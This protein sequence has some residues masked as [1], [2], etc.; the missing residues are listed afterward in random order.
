MEKMERN[1]RERVEK[2]NMRAQAQ[3]I[4][5]TADVYDRI[6][7]GK[8]DKDDAYYL[9][10]LFRITDLLNKRANSV[11]DVHPYMPNPFDKLEGMSKEEIRDWIH[12]EAMKYAEGFKLCSEE[13]GL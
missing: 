4:R 2:I 3:L 6:V 1:I 12:A 7:D 9:A 10:A 5:L 11:P 13:E 8:D